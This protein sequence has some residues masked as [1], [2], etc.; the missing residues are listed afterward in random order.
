MKIGSVKKL[1]TW[2]LRQRDATARKVAEEEDNYMNLYRKRLV[3]QVEAYDRVLNR[4]DAFIRFH[5]DKWHDR[6]KR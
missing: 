4:V 6:R 3:G 5:H 1:R 2:I